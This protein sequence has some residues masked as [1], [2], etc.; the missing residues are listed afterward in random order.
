LTGPIGKALATGTGDI[1]RV[2]QSKPAWDVDD[3][4]GPSTLPADELPRLGN[5]DDGLIT[6]DPSALETGCANVMAS[7]PHR[8]V[9]R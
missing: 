8:P 3:N 6:V 7:R 2:A 1:N 9:A 4:R 5:G